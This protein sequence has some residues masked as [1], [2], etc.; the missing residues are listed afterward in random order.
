M[1]Q[2]LLDFSTIVEAKKANDWK[3]VNEA[4]LARIFQHFQDMKMGKENASFAILTSWRASFS[5]QENEAR[6]EDL[7]QTLREMGYGFIRLTGHWKECQDENIPYDQCPPDKLKDSI[8]PSLFIPNITKD[9]AVAVGNKY[10][11]DAIVFAGPETGGKVTLL[12]RGGD[13]MEIGD[14]EPGS[15]TQAYST[16]K[17][18]DFHFEWVA[19]TNTEKL[20]EKLFS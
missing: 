1:T 17:K 3:L 16:W 12:F 10:S 4:S 13:S 15:V 5:K 9:K 6:L 8:E 14:F 20:I 18:R 2:K 19:Q 7:K 11:Q